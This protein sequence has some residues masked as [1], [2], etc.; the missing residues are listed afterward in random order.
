MVVAIPE[1]SA[2]TKSLPLENSSVLLFEYRQLACHLLS[3]DLLFQWLYK[4]AP[5]AS[6]KSY[7]CF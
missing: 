7:H 5:P 4:G 1:G 6:L 2:Q 3:H